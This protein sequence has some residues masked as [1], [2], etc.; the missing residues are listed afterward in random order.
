MNIK[1]KCNLL[2]VDEAGNICV[3]FKELLKSLDNMDDRIM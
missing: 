2:L 1:C 3:K